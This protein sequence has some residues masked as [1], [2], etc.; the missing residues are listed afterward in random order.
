MRY[1]A[2][3]IATAA[4]LSA[5]PSLQLG[6]SPART[7]PPRKKLDQKQSPPRKKKTARSRRAVAPVE[8]P[9]FVSS[10]TISK[11]EEELYDLAT[12]WFGRTPPFVIG[13]VRDDVEHRRYVIL[14]QQ[15]QQGI[16]QS[17]TIAWE[18]SY[19]GCNEDEKYL[20]NS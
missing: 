12:Q 10:E 18:G 7:M 13:E 3:L 16:K 6:A 20:G 11:E 8:R 2:L 15:S 19:A 17:C 1:I 14:T 5:V 4:H 9:D